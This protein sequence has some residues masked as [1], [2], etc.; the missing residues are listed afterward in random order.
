MGKMIP[1]PWLKDFVLDE[2]RPLV[3]V[4]LPPL[5]QPITH[6]AVRRVARA[7]NGEE[8]ILLPDSLQ[9]N[10]VYLQLEST[11]MPRD[12][13]A[14]ASVVKRLEEAQKQLP[15][16]LNLFILDT[17]R[18]LAFQKELGEIYLA[19]D[20]ELRPGSVASASDTDIDPP[21][22]TGGAVDLTLSYKGIG[23]RLGTD[24]D[25]FDDLA[26]SN[27]FESIVRES[28]PYTLLVRDLRRLLS[29]VLTEQGFAPYLQEWWHFSYGDQR[30]AAQYGFNSSL[31]SMIQ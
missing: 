24:F 21:H 13:Y 5:I 17:W 10:H 12:M 15:E 16:D 4:D 25:S 8:L 20:P 29:L 31:F 22:T 1:R 19:E 30:W 6:D 2:L 14:R 18:T 11:T 3:P 26:E 7:E 9:Q 28:D 27:Y 23:L